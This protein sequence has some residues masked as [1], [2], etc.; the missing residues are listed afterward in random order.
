LQFIETE[1]TFGFVPLMIVLSGNR[2]R[3][4]SQDSNPLLLAS[5]SYASTLLLVSS[6]ALLL[7]RVGIEANPWLLTFILSTTSLGVLLPI[8]KE[9]KL[10]RTPFGQGMFITATLADFATVILLTVY[11]NVQARGLDP[12]IFSN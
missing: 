1:A 12:E 6:G 11:L 4:K 7:H 2:S 8:L 10:M 9:R 5:I 3:R